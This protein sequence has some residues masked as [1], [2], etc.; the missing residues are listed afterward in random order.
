MA[1]VHKSQSHSSTAGASRPGRAEAADPEEAGSRRPSRA[2]LMSLT[3]LALLLMLALSGFA[4]S[5][6]A[7]TIVAYD[8]G[9]TGQVG[10]TNQIPGQSVTT[11]SGGSWTD[12]TFNFYNASTGAAVASGNLYLFT[13]T[14]GGTASSLS[15]QASSSAGYVATAAASG[16]VYV[17]GPSVTL[18]AGTVYYFYADSQPSPVDGLSGT[19]N[20]G[21]ADGQRYFSGNAGT[22]NFGAA[23]ATQD[24]AFNLSTSAPGPIPGAGLLSYAVVLIGGVGLRFRLCL[25]AARKTCRRLSLLLR[26]SQARA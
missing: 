20:S 21:Y 15:S 23:A 16:S 10:N 1:S 6:K 25:A 18:L 4:S 17:F 7:A 2:D 5:A 11:P 26:M 22:L 8:A 3:A 14:Y 9:G 24:Y 13:Q 12:I 19:S